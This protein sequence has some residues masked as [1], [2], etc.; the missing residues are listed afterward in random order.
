MLNAQETQ[1]VFLPNSK[2]LSHF[3][4][5]AHPQSSVLIY[6]EVLKVNVAAQNLIQV[7][8]ERAYPCKAGE[9]LKS[10]E[11][12]PSH[13]QRLLAFS[14]PVH[15]Y[16]LGG[17][18]IT[19]FTGFIASIFKRGVSY[20]VIPSTWLAAVDAAHGG[21]TALN[22]G[23][24]KNQIG[25]F[26]LPKVCYLIEDLLLSQPLKN[27]YEA[28]AEVLKTQILMGNDESTETPT[29]L[30][31]NLK[32]LIDFKLKI[33]SADLYDQKGI[34][35][36][37]N[38]GHTFGHLLEAYYKLSHGQAVALGLKFAYQWS[39]NRGI[40]NP[41]HS[42]L[43]EERIHQLISNLKEHAQTPLFN[44]VIEQKLKIPENKAVEY[45]SQ[46]K[47]VSNALESSRNQDTI[48][49]HFIGIED[50]GKPHIE[51]MLLS[52]LIFELKKQAYIE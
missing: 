40:L 10:V 35:A 26:H 22:V 17:G 25:S 9:T 13:L 4:N 45:L 24:I 11:H 16:A 29:K 14:Y 1:L 3:K 31:K 27:F 23:G 39:K 52:E 6:D 49:I 20:S 43:I 44:E 18:S 51:P 33:V 50:L 38:L 47:K 2:N 19:D 15:F 12:L 8:Q 21:K 36:Q 7:F 41:A 42:M 46:D 32:P 30:F 37:L 48:K 34:R 5:V 28:Q